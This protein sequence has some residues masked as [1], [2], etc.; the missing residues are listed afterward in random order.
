[1]L[2]RP[3]QL[4]PE[5]HFSAYLTLLYRVTVYV[6]NMTAHPEQVTPEQI[7]EIHELMDAVH[8]IPEFVMEHGYY[9]TEQMMR[10]F[11]ID[12][13]DQKFAGSGRLQLATVLEDSLRQVRE[14]DDHAA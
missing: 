5:P 11:H 9:F 6:R 12:A 10:E 3:K 8:N 13:F 1:M 7:R 4:A 14:R 2:N